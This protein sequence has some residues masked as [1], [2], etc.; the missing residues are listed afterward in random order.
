MKQVR[1]ECINMRGQAQGLASQYQLHVRCSYLWLNRKL[2]GNVWIKKSAC[3][4]GE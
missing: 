3:E 2:Y 1:I 4:E